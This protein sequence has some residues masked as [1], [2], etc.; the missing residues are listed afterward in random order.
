MA[1]PT[2]TNRF[3]ILLGDGAEPEE[4]AFPCGARTRNFTITNNM[5]EQVVMDCDAPLDTLAS[6]VRSP[7]SQDVS[8]SIAGIVSIEAWPMW[9]AFSMSTLPRNVRIALDEPLARG[10][11]H[12]TLPAFLQS[13]EFGGE[14]TSTATFTANLVGAGQLV[15]VDAAA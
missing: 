11:G 15:W 8:M 5:D 6:I 3:L 14:T 7:I 13:M 4:F 12:F 9:R 10:G 1:Q 2:L